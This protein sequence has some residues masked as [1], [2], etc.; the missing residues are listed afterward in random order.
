MYQLELELSKGLLGE[1]RFDASA[2]ALY[3]SDAS[4]YRQVPL[5]V[6][7]PR[8]VEDLAKALEICRRY[9]VPFLTRGG[10]T[11]QNGQCVNVAVVADSSKYV[12]RIVSIDP[13]AR[14]AVVE[15][16]VICDALRDAAAQH[17]L[18]FG[19]DPATHS[20]CTLG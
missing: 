14:T 10:G 6:I 20:R 7:V 5:G 1:V 2:K 12:N 17:G 11:S 15:P 8:N 3:A 4:N 9:D 19:P 16:G 18:T 13:L